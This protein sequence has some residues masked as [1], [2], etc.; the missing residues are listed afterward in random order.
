MAWRDRFAKASHGQAS[1]YVGGMDSVPARLH[2]DEVI[3]RKPSLGKRGFF[4][5]IGIVAAV[6][7]GVGAMFVRMG[8]SPVPIFLGLDVVAV[9]LAFRASY[10]QAQRRE[11]VRISSDL[12]EVIRED[13]GKAETVWSTPTAFTRVALEARGRYAP[14]VRIRM[15]RRAVSVGQTLG[16]RQR[17]D[18]A[19]AIDAAIRAARSER[20][21]P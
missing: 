1:A 5:L 18:L 4:I 16:P 13:G 21:Q 20:Y 19:E 11:R 12:V 2:L 3:A 17:S 15:S 10:R 7:V 9:W 6:N 14:E 8:A